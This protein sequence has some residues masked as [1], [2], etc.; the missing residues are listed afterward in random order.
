MPVLKGADF[1]QSLVHKAYVIFTTAYRDYVVEDF[2]LNAINCVLK[3]NVF[4]VFSKSLGNSNTEH[5]INKN[6]KKRPPRKS[7]QKTK[8]LSVRTKHKKLQINNIQHN[9]VR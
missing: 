1:Y 2:E 3:P 8:T 5:R 7:F 6:T 4:T 9:K